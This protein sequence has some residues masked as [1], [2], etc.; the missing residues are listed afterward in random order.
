MQ[1]TVHAESR[2]KHTQQ[3]YNPLRR[4]CP[5]SHV[6]KRSCDPVGPGEVPSGEREKQKLHTHLSKQSC[7]SWC[8]KLERGNC[9]EQYWHSAGS[10]EMAFSTAKLREQIVLLISHRQLGH[11]ADSSLRRASASRWA[12]QL[13]HIRC[14]LGHCN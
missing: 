8:S 4:P 2:T 11:V 7:F 3:Q 12:K 14:P 6:T 13:A 9:C 10:S 1:Y 5:S